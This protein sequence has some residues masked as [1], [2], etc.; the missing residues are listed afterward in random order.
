[1][2]IK[3]WIFSLSERYSDTVSLLPDFLRVGF[4]YL[5]AVKEITQ[6]ESM[7][8]ELME[9][10]VFKR[11]RDIVHHAYRNV[12]F[13]RDFYAAR[14]FTP[15]M[16]Q[17]PTD[18]HKVP[19]VN[20]R[21]LQ[22]AALEYR[23][24]P[25]VSGTPS[26]TGGT[27]GTP[28]AFLLG[29]SALPVEWAHMHAIWK[30]HGY[31]CKHLKLRIGGT[32]AAGDVPLSYH[33]RHNEFVVNANCSLSKVI[34]AVLSLPIRHKV[35]WIHGYPSVVAE[36][37]HALAAHG[38]KA[39]EI[40]RS[41]LYG[42]LLCSEF[43]V[44]LYREPISRILSTNIVSWYGHS[45]MAL[46]A[47]ETGAGIYQSFASYGL[48]EAVPGVDGRHHS[49]VCSSLHNRVH[50]FIRYDTGDLIQPLSSVGASLAFRI[51]EGRVG[52][53]VTDRNGRRLALTSIIFGRHHP[54]FDEVLHLQVCQDEPGRVTL[55]VVPRAMSID[56][57]ALRAGFDFSGLDLE[58]HLEVISEPIRSKLGKVKL[59]IE[60]RE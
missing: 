8:P 5:G 24:A 9:L 60:S 56:L 40:F 2:S 6:A 4:G 37:A 29:Q 42:V 19:V 41:S 50:P 13:Y 11:L 54:G 47:R 34:E 26:N 20:K 25:C 27:S 33:P 57:E 38:G 23:C 31:C 45:E 43:P 18:W 22:A 7:T 44:P 3:Q 35:R 1:M 59:K 55:L 51:T 30:A 52:D 46:L 21:D 48:A 10:Q 14:D 39:A 58:W 28:L 36:F 15:D 49:L 12:P 16:L 17:G 32:Y 53:F